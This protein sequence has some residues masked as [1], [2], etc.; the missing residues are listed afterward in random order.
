MALLIKLSSTLRNY[1]NGYDP[2]QGLEF[3]LETGRSVVQVVESLGIPP[4]KIKFAMINGIHA[5][6]DQELADGDRLGLF[7]AVG[8]G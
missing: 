5:G 4:E 6:L 3:E 8:G 7:P 2:V 1:V